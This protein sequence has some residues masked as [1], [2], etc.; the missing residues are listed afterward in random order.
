MMNL[1]VEIILI[2]VSNLDSKNLGNLRL[3]NRALAGACAECIVRNGISI[4]N[5]TRW[6]EDLE[7]FLTRQ[8][9]VKFTKQVTIYS[10]QWPLYT[11]QAQEEVEKTFLGYSPFVKE[12]IIKYNREVYTIRHTLL[13]LG[14]LHTI[15]ISHANN[16]SQIQKYQNLPR[17]IKMTFEVS[18]EVAPTVQSFLLAYGNGQYAENNIRTLNINGRFDPGHVYLGSAPCCFRNIQKLY[19]ESF[20]VRYNEDVIKNFLQSFPDLLELS[21]SFQ[22]WGDCLGWGYEFPLLFKG[23]FWLHLQTFY[24]TEA[25]ITEDDLFEII[26]RHCNT[27]RS[28]TLGNVALPI[29][30]WQSY[31][32]R[33]RGLESQ[34]N[35]IVKGKLFSQGVKELLD[36]STKTDY[37]YM[38]TNFMQD[39]Y[40]HWPFSRQRH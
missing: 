26:E 15:V 34:T 4:M 8:Y 33:V 31:F 13:S 32:T 35:V 1:P 39:K 22:G 18:D 40:C 14:Q 28:V 37:T 19:I 5:A 12:R 36:F 23:S 21:L 11:R 38:L 27:L 2:I 25:L 3:V 9:V 16:V 30:S 24:I 20:Q 6:L 29:G 7:Y 17:D 10:G